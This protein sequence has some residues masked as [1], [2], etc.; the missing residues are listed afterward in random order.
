MTA[1]EEANG[2]LLQHI[3]DFFCEQYP[4]VLQEAL[5]AFPD[6]DWLQARRGGYRCLRPAA[7]VVAF[8]G[9]SRPAPGVEEP[10]GDSDI[11]LERTS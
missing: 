10:V 3:I 6:Q 1:E 7:C 4:N 11:R 2:R 9:P 5:D 8:T